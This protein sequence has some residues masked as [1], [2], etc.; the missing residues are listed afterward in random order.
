MEFTTTKLRKY[1][2]P[3]EIV[4]KIGWVEN[5]W[6]KDLIKSSSNKTPFIQK[7]IPR[8]QLYCLMSSAESFTEFHID[9]GGSSVWYHVF[10][11]KKVNPFCHIP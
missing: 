5:L 6:P 10:Q 1:I 8:V 7:K 11:G 2:S 3:P 4:N 9:F